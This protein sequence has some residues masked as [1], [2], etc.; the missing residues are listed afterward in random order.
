MGIRFEWDEGKAELNHRKHRI[1]FEEAMTVFA[2]RRLS[3]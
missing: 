1:A 3:G 2:D